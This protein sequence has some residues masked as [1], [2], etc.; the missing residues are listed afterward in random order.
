MK[1][2]IRWQLLLAA[3]GF[4]LI[5]ALLSY[6]VQ[7]AGLCTVQVP[8]EGGVYAE[9]ILG[10]PQYI[11]PLLADPN[12]VDR[13]LSSLIFDG[14]TRY[15]NGVPVPVLAESWEVSEDGRT[16]RFFLREDVSWHDGRPLTV[17]D[18]LFTYGLLQSDDF[19]GDPALTRLWQS[20]IMRGIDE[21]TIEFELPEPYSGFLEATTR[22]IMPA[23]V[24]EGVTAATLADSSFNRQP[25][26]TGPFMVDSSQNWEASRG[27][28]LSPFLDAWSSAA[29]IGNLLFRFYASESELLEAFERGEI[30]AINSVSPVMLPE[31]AEVPQ[32]RLF[33]TS[34][35]RYTA[36]LFN[37]TESGSAATQSGAVRH[38][39]AMGLDR[40]K[41][42]DETINGQGIVQN[43]PYLT[44]SWAHNSSVTMIDSFQPISATVALE[45]SGWVLSEGETIRRLQ[46]QP[47]ILRFLVYDT[48]T[49]RVIAESISEQWTELGIAPQLLLF[50]N[51]REFRQNLAAGEFDVALVDITPP[52]DPDLYDFWSQEAIVRGQNYAGWNRRRAS[53]A[54]ENGRRLWSIEERKPFYDSFLRYYSE[55]LPELTLFQHV[56]TYA[57]NEAV[58]GVEIGRIG[59]PRDRYASMA[60]WILRH[61]DVTVAC[62]DESV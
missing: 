18:V 42:V 20:V 46:E 5:L 39:L 51:W 16:V 35:P 22:G 14:L 13:E 17:D 7:S 59:H 48:P 45:D 36:L 60:N 33:S 3:A 10:A 21:R 40:D 4:G 52:G 55:D 1:P 23:H 34:V 6:Q 26:G 27:L 50:T 37:M 53:E 47:M 15:E 56:Y 25:I 62:P 38:A 2:D 29:Q 43:G 9:G 61:R 24:L 8:A 12:P 58:T 30:Q 54:L 31:L 28:S 41:L 49:N 57:V 11:N 19:T 32:A 44:S